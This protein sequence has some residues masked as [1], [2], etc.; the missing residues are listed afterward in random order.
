VNLFSNANDW[1]TRTDLIY[2][3]QEKLDDVDKFMN[4][5]DDGKYMFYLK[6]NYSYNLIYID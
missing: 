3:I 5:I 4:R 6:K 1:T 2:S